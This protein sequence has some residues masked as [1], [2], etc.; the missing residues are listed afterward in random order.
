MTSHE[1]A[2]KLLKGPD[3]KVLVYI[4][5]KKNEAEEVKY[6]HILGWNEKGVRKE[7]LIL[8][9]ESYETFSKEELNRSLI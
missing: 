1:L 5:N 3:L 6:A 7:D 2:R 4:T 9:G 8:R